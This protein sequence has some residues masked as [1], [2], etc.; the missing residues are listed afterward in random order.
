MKSLVIYKD[1]AIKWVDECWQRMRAEALFVGSNRLPDTPEA[2]VI[3]TGMSV[4]R[5]EFENIS[6]DMQFPIYREY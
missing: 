2:A 4:V 3:H 1:G 6:R 5:K